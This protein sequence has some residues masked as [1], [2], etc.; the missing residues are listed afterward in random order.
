[1]QPAPTRFSQTLSANPV[2]PN[3]V[4]SGESSEQLE[5]R[6]ANVHIKKPSKS[7]NIRYIVIRQA[8]KWQHNWQQTGN[9]PATQGWWA[10]G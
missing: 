1:L 4:P 3:D 7:G 10:K 6:Q 5:R 9:R 8:F 2:V